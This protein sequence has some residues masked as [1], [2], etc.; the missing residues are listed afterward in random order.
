MVDDLHTPAD[1]L[2]LA[3]DA[4]ELTRGQQIDGTLPVKVAV[5]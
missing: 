3:E 5:A 4:I 1:A 2:G